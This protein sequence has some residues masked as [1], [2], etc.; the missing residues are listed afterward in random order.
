MPNIVGKM[1]TLLILILLKLFA[2]PN[3]Y[4]N[5]T[6]LMH[7][8]FIKNIVMLSTVILPS[9]FYQIVGNFTLNLTSPDSSSF[10]RI[11]KH[12]SLLFSYLSMHWLFC[13]TLGSLYKM[14]ITADFSISL[15]PKNGMLSVTG[16]AVCNF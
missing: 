13:F 15:C 3:L 2:N 12:P 4:F 9:L 10:S 14:Y 7:S 1:A 5:L 16:S 8:A 6:S 11:Y